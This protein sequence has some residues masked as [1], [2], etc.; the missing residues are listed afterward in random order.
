[1][2]GFL[3]DTNVISELVKPRP[4]AGVTK[5]ISSVEEESLYLSVLTFGEIRKG[6]NLLPANARRASLE[7]WLERDLVIR[8]AGRILPID[9]E[10]ADRWGQI[11]AE[12]SIKKKV[13]PV[14]D[15]LIAATALERNLT[16]VTRNSG[17]IELTKVPVLNPWS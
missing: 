12:I 4:N 10:V 6:I 9:R 13:L 5:W 16:A 8:F 15:G 7:S 11:S 3:L 17:D 1:M 14:I 2:N